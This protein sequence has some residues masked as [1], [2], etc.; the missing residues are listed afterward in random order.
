M[1]QKETHRNKRFL[2]IKATIDLNHPL[3]RGTVLKDCEAVGELSKEGFEELD[4]RDL[5]YGAW[6]RRLCY[7]RSQKFNRRKIPTQDHATRVSS[8][9]HM[10]RVENNLEIEAVAESLGA[11]ELSKGVEKLDATSKGAIVNWKKWTKK[12]APRKEMSGVN[13]KLEVEIGKRHLVDVMIIDG[14]REIGGKGKKKLKGQ[15]MEK[16]N[17]EN[18]PEVVLDCPMKILSWNYM[19]LRNP[20]RVQS[21]SRLTNLENTMVVFLS[22]TRLTKVEMERIRLWCGVDSYLGVSCTGE[23]R[24]KAGGIALLWKESLNLFVNSFSENHIEASFVNDVS[25]DTL[26]VFTGS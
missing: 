24:N 13:K 20:C 14:T 4:E 25:G 21:L 10:T 17:C 19:G 18:E 8:A 3:K 26:V 23:R 12:Q 1:D 22:E 2:R 9:F 16:I 11:V 6:L 7:L 15:D 5:S